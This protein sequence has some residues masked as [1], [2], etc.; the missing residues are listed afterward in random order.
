MTVE[1]VSAGEIME[2]MTGSKS[3]RQGWPRAASALSQVIR[4]G[5]PYSVA[6]N[7]A[8]G[9]LRVNLTTFSKIVGI[10]MRTMS[11]REAQGRFT[12][13][14]SD[15]VYR[16]A[17][18]AAIARKIFGDYETAADW[19]KRGNMAL[20][21]VAPITMLDNDVDVREVENLLGQIEHGVY[22]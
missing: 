6:K 21:G 1:A 18:I 4:R 13:E 22:R 7:L 12:P 14:E 9:R 3:R 5:L 10:P 2:T 16:V 8:E 15:R 17:Y 20:G 19:L 11:R